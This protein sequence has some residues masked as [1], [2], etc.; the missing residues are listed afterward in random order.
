MELA[1]GEALETSEGF[2]SV[3]SVM[4]LRGAIDVYN[5]EVA[6]YHEYLAGSVGLRAH[7]FC[8]I[9][10]VFDSAGRVQSASAKI[11][12]SDI[13]TGTGTTEASRATARAMGNATDDAG[14]IVGRLLG[15]PGGKTA[16]N[17]FAQNPHINRGDYRV[18][19]GF[20]A[21]QVKS[22]S[23]VTVDIKLLYRG[24]SKRP[25]RIVYDAMIDGQ[26]HREVF[27]N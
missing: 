23:T 2:A 11:L 13:G 16:K 19:E 15:G 17:F 27:G 25:W 18:F 22:G 9:K 4:P 24:G 26:L 7:N 5:V 20:I 14:H 6:G 3:R 21:S 8:N 1:V 12:K 10:L